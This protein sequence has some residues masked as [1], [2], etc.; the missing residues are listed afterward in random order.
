M[1]IKVPSALHISQS[2]VGRPYSAF[3]SFFNN[4]M[5]LTQTEG[6]PV[7]YRQIEN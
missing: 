2:R 4:F 7:P 3:K 6:T 5:I 1:V